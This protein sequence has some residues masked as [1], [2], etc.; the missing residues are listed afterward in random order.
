MKLVIKEVKELP[1]EITQLANNSKKEGFDFIE[2]MIE[3]FNSGKNCFNQPGEFL[4][5]AYDNDK[6]IACGG[7]NLQWNEQDVE[8]RIG[9]V[10]RFYVLPEYRQHGVG[11]LLL[12]YLEKKA[13]VD[14]SALCLYTS[15]KDAA[16]FYKKMNYVFVENHPNYNY[17]KYLI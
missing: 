3:E 16:G 9:R 8:S 11:K 5:V 15:L 6:L 12:Q 2:R 13:I 10:R 14:F 7:L 1:P 17:F 4:L